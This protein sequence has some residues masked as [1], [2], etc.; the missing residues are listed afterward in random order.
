M[1]NAGD[2]NRNRPDPLIT[3]LTRQN[4]GVPG[5]FP[6]YGH[7]FVDRELTYRSLMLVIRSAAARRASPKTRSSPADQARSPETGP[8]W[9]EHHEPLLPTGAS[10]AHTM[11]HHR[12]S[13]RQGVRNWT[14]CTGLHRFPAA[15]IS[16]QISTQARSEVEPKGGICWSQPLISVT[17]QCA[18][19]AF[20]HGHEDSISCRSLC[21][22]MCGGE[23]RAASRES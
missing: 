14:G 21:R 7:A 11:S 13:G 18:S 2:R 5:G 15:A 17:E 19:P 20:Q 9:R 1:R 16:T 22:R 12:V 6:G 10:N 4:Q 3:L 8:R 23:R